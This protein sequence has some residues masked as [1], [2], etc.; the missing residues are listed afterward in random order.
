VRISELFGALHLPL[1]LNVVLLALYSWLAFAASRLLAREAFVPAPALFLALVLSGGADLLGML[2]LDVKI[3][4]LPPGEAALRVPW[5]LEWWGRPFA[6]QSP[7]AH[8]YWAPQHFFGALVGTA[9][10]IQALRSSGRASAALLDIGVLIAA[11][12]HWSPYVAVGIAALA[13]VQLFLVDGQLL[14]RAWEE[15]FA[16]FARAQ[17]LAAGAFAAAMLAFTAVFFLAAKP[18][19]RPT[20][21]VSERPVDWLLTF[22]FNYAPFILTLAILL[23]IRFFVGA[24]SRI[25]QDTHRKLVSAFAGLLAASALLLTLAHGIYNDWGMRTT[26]PVWIGLMTATVTVL[27]MPIG[28]I[29]RGAIVVALLL[30][31]ADSFSEIAI[32]VQGTPNCSGY[33]AFTLNDLGALSPQYEGRPDSFLYRHLARNH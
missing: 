2:A 21:L 13:A 5:N 23:G 32:S 9:L 18:L 4:L 30:C 31:S 24:T 12:A 29:A 20:V 14:G 33:G 8:L 7:T 28:N 15:G 6:P 25:P 27:F 26:L 16:A 19:S 22:L 3:E 17:T 1:S 11:A 10:V